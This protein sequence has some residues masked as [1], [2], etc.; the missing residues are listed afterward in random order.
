MT[1]VLRETLNAFR[2]A[3]LLSALSIT[4]IAFSL[5][6]F[7]L[8]G[9]VAVN[10]Q[11][12][13]GDVAER[14]EIVAY[15]KRGT[16]VET[17]TRAVADI[18]GIPQVESV[19]HVTEAEALARARRELREFHD[20]FQDLEANPL[21]ASLEIRLKPEHRNAESAEAVAGML[22][23]GFPMIDDVR[24]GQDWIEKLDRLRNIAGAVGF[25]IGAA[26]A[27]V[28]VIIIG[29][30]I[31]MAVLQRSNEISIMRLVG[32][33]DGFIRLP[34]LLEG[35]LKG[36]IGGAAALALAYGAYALV[37]SNLNFQAMFFTTPQAVLGVLAGG[38]IGL[39]GSAVSV[40]RHLKSV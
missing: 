2:R 5:F 34:F 21:P 29:T 38:V 20:I 17:I 11:H 39:L 24:Y 3:P 16:N 30:T 28:A 12:T 23:H 35:M 32:A 26:F 37:E 22:R 6:V 31:R 4:T 15:L 27:L 14:V 33:T 40:G 18:E 25:A 13:I 36:L 9:L 8:F 1:L 7:G 19:E 10:L